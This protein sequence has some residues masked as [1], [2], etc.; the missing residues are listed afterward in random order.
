MQVL[1]LVPARGG[2]KGVP[3]KNI[4][5]L[6]G[7]PLIAHTIAYAAAARGVSRVVVSTDSDAIAEVSRQEGADVPFLRPADLAA[8]DTPM[9]A[10]VAH[11][12]EWLATHEA[13]VPDAVVLLQPTVPFRDATLMDRTLAMLRDGADAVV[14]VAPVPTAYHA[15]WQFE[16]RDGVLCRMDG[17]DLAAIVTRRQDL[18]PAFVRD[19]AIY[20]FRRP[21]FTA[22]GSFYSDRT[23]ALVNQSTVNIDTAADWLLAESMAETWTPNR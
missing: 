4:K 8:D 13:W 10:V 19:G 6:A 14:S 3:G 20:G 21:M 17:G 12:L 11:A 9:K 22:T 5:R 18:R 23:M 2:S 16:V 1:A 15:D 7:R